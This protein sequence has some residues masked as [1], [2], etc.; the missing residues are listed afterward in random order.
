MSRPHT[1]ETLL[2]RVYREQECWIWAG[3][4]NGQGYGSVTWNGKQWRAHRLVYELLVGPIPT[5]TLD[6]LCRNRKCVN[7]AHLE[8][9]SN[10]TNVL[11][12]QGVTARNSRATSC[13]HGHPFT[14]ENTRITRKGRDCRRCYLLRHRHR[15]KTWRLARRQQIAAAIRAR[16]EKG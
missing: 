4:D 9:A 3:C 13:K 2:S 11:R 16:E 1:I 15:Q 14:S 5:E 6:H 8:P 12:G 7:P 10:K